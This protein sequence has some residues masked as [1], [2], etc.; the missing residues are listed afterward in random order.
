M[1]MQVTEFCS[2]CGRLGGDAPFRVCA[3]CGLGVY[4]RTDARALHADGAPFLVVRADGVISAASATAEREF[5]HEGPLVGRP[6]RTLF[7]SEDD[8]EGAVSLAAAGATD[9]ASMS[10]TPRHGGR[11][12]RVTIAPCGEPPAALIAVTRK[13]AATARS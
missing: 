6:L 11:R 4:L 1:D 10:V 7:T 8:L 9:V 12:V 2:Y 13:P 3:T 5:P